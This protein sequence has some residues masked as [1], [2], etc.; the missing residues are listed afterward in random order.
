MAARQSCIGHAPDA[1]GIGYRALIVRV[2]SQ[3]CAAAPYKVKRP[4]PVVCRQVGI[5]GGATYLVKQIVS[6]ETTA[7]RHRDEMLHQHV[8]WLLG[9][10]SCFDM[11]VG[12]CCPRG[13]AFNHFKAVRGHQRDARRSARCMTRT[14]GT[15]QQPRHT[16]GRTD[17]Q[18]AFD[19][20]K[21]NTEVKA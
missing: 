10:R 17:L 18:H 12:N 20:Q 4:F 14:T 1:L 7:Q 21:V 19:R 16:L 15:L 2:G 3:R 9:R 5:G 11:A 8:E 13:R 6:D